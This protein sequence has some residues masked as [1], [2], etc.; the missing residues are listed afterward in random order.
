MESE[1]QVQEGTGWIAIPD[2]GKIN[3]RRDSATGA[4]QYFTA[5]VDDD[6]YA[7]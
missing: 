1:W 6:E 2:F 4:R 5:K 3:P 7:K